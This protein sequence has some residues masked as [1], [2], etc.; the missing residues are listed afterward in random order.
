MTG[1]VTQLLQD[2]SAGHRGSLDAVMPLIYEALANTARSQLRGE[3]AG[4]TLST[5][6]LINETYL[7]LAEQDRVQWQNRAHFLAVASL[8]MRRILVNYAKQGSRLKRGGGEEPVEL[9][10]AVHVAADQP[11]LDVEALDQALQRLTDIDERAARVV[12]CRYFGG[13]G[14]EETAEALNIAPATVKRDWL[15]AKTWL[16]RELA[17]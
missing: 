17:I 15:M 12:E 4:H 11:N 3:R 13:L 7:R 16:R 9:E 6:A 5:G 2:A 10:H 8:L 1:P 14:I